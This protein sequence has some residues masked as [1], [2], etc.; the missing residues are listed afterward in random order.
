[1]LKVDDAEGIFFGIIY[2]I[3]GQI[4]IHDGSSRDKPFRIGMTSKALLLSISKA[5]Y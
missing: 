5:L 4:V 1:M 3:K 2:D